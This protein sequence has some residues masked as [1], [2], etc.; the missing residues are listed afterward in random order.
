MKSINM[1][2]KGKSLITIASRILIAPLA[3]ILIFLIADSSKDYLSN[4]WAKTLT[5]SFTLLVLVILSLHRGS[6]AQTSVK[7]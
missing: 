7:N 5:V 2:F 6:A 3:C 1:I 4:S